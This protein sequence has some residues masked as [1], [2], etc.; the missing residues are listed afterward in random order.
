MHTAY[1]THRARHHPF[2][3]GPP[4]CPPHASRHTDFWKHSAP[5][6][7]NHSLGACPS[8]MT[9]EKRRVASSRTSADHESISGSA[10]SPRKVCSRLER[11][12]LARVSSA[13]ARLARAPSA[14]GTGSTPSPALAPRPSRWR[15]RFETSWASATGASAAQN[16]SRAEELNCARL[17]MTPHA[18]STT[19]LFQWPSS[20]TKVGAPSADTSARCAHRRRVVATEVAQLAERDVA[21]PRPP[22]GAHVLQHERPLHRAGARHSL[23][24]RLE[25]RAV[26]RVLSLGG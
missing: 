21:L 10:T 15:A 18:R 26:V 2:H 1:R 5:P 12:N 11:R 3:A 14:C 6:T 19:S 25:R 23:V 13:K 22:L 8:A 17:R 16:A 20:A 4:A 7:S 24:R 9:H